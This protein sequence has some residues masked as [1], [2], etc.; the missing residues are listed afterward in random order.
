MSGR[1]MSVDDSATLFHV[2]S[3]VHAG[4]RGRRVCLQND[5]RKGSRASHSPAGDRE[6]AYAVDLRSDEAGSCASTVMRGGSLSGHPLHHS[7]SSRS[8]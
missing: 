8:A 3:E 2:Y 4:S 5:L 7:A 1:S 6:R